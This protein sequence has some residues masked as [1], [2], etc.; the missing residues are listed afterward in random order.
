VFTIP[1]AAGSAKK[2]L[3]AARLHLFSD[4]QFPNSPIPDRL[5]SFLARVHSR[6]SVGKVGFVF[7]L[8]NYQIT[9]LPNQSIF[10]PDPP[11]TPHPPLPPF[12]CVSKL[13]LL[14]F[15]V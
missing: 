4:F 2:G 9:H 14:F 15:S 3:L 8:P 13:L 12:P 5:T 7:Q 10:F 1:P 6:W 11:I